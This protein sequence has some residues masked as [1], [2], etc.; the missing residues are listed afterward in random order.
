[1]DC[2]PAQNRCA[3]IDNDIILYDRMAGMPFDQHTL[4]V[5]SETL[6]SQGHLLIQTHTFANDRC[7]TNAH[8]DTVINEETGAYLRT[9]VNINACRLL[10]KAGNH[11]GKKLQ[12]HPVQG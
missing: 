8:T 10:R 5:G 6:G 7:F 12:T 9:R 3:S 1:A 11:T 4:V 2:D